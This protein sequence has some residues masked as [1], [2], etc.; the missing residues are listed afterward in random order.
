V[1]PARQFHS[2]RRRRCLLHSRRQQM[3]ALNFVNFFLWNDLS[4]LKEKSLQ[5]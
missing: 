2:H 5:V 4:K 3:A 1:R